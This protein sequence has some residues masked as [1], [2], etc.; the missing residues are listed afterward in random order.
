MSILICRKLQSAENTPLIRE[1]RCNVTVT[2]DDDESI[3][4]NE[5]RF[6]PGNVYGP[7]C[8]IFTM[9]LLTLH[10]MR[11]LNFAPPLFD[12]NTSGFFFIIFTSPVDY[13]IF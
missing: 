8:I 6:I 2:D 1:L 9:T 13:S 7:V 4:G 5:T 10:N 11:T 3:H 12:Y